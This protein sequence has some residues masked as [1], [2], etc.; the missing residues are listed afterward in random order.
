[1]EYEKRHGYRG[2]EAI[3]SIPEGKEAAEDAIEKAL[4]EHSNSDDL[5][6]AMVLDATPKS[7]RAILAS[8]E[9]IRMDE[10]GI[11]FAA[12]GLSAKA[13]ANKRIQRGAVIR[14][15]QEGKTGSSRRCLKC[16]RR[17]WPPAPPMAQ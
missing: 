13:P 11:S 9:E 4:A 3:I 12:S 10:A 8:G 1:M 17:S 6:V 7:V 14:V 16:S 2:P 5:Q 15:M